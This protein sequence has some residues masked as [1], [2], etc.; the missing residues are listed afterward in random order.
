[1]A[2]IPAVFNILD[3]INASRERK[4]TEFE[5]CVTLSVLAPALKAMEQETAPPRFPTVAATTGSSK[6]TSA[7]AVLVTLCAEGGTG[8]YIA[9]EVTLCDEFYR[10]VI[11]L[12]TTQSIPGLSPSDVAIYTGAHRQYPIAESLKK[13]EAIL[14]QGT[15][16]ERTK[17]KDFQ[18]AQ[19][20]ITTHDFWMKDITQGSQNGSRHWYQ[21]GK[22]H[23]HRNLIMA[24][25]E[26]SL[27]RTFIADPSDIEALADAL[28]NT[29]TV[30][31]EVAPLLR[32][33]A[34]RMATIKDNL[35]KPGLQLPEQALVN[36]SEG[37]LLE[38][39][40]AMSRIEEAAKKQ[41][42]PDF[43]RFFN[44]YMHTAYFLK[45]T[46]RG[47]VYYAR[48]LSG[49][50]HAWDIAIPPQ[51][52][53][54][55]MDGTGDLDYVALDTHT[56][57]HPVPPSSYGKLDVH[58]ILPP[59]E[60]RDFLKPSKGN[61]SS[62]LVL[63]SY[64]QKFIKPLILEYTEPG[65]SVLVY[66]KKSFLDRG[67]HLEG[68]ES[69]AQS[70]YEATIEGRKLYFVSYGRGRGSNNYRD[71]K[72][73]FRISDHFPNKGA[74]MAQYA[75]FTGQDYSP[76][77]LTRLSAPRSRDPR[78]EQACDSWLAIHN[79]QDAARA[80]IRNL[81]D[82]GDAGELRA[83]LVDGPLD[84]FLRY[85]QVMFPG[86]PPVKLIG[87]DQE[88]LTPPEKLRTLLLTAEEK[89]LPLAD[90]AERSGLHKQA[91]L[92]TMRSKRCRPA[93][94]AR[95]WRKSTAKAEGLT[96]IHGGATVF[97]RDAAA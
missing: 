86:S 18:H 24:D 40:L 62:P 72:V 52:R 64:W 75:S 84:H 34:G 67:F 23:S 66:L 20:V 37:M 74:L 32:E 5:R 3:K 19:L 31:P 97:V 65:E 88:E 90:V 13:A 77:D 68:D 91:V 28:V 69:Q 1:M 30:K 93:V 85:Q 94:E 58:H 29:E 4:G 36:Q 26:P 83:Y 92:R 12:L 44:G 9:P 95:N 43:M 10:G 87:H 41:G 38:H 2:T 80:H 35:F 7:M 57:L 14:G 8:A 15:I 45:A 48:D 16:T 73:Y 50:F 27:S 42:G 79:K 76:E 89:V 78:W 59:P 61:W 17:L 56:T 63:K 25:E 47:K 21:D 70:D 55:I 39:E 53:T 54:V 60:W 6:T 96:D 46:A 82:E 81:D 22:V 33:I 49:Q 71:C 51:P 11:K